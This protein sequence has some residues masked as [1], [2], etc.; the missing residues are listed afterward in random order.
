MSRYLQDAVNTPI[1]HAHPINGSQLDGNRNLSSPTAYYKPN[2]GVY[3]FVDP[4][5]VATPRQL[6]FYQRDSFGSL[7]TTVALHSFYQD[8][9]PVTWAW[10]DGTPNTVGNRI[11]RHT[12]AAA[13]TYTVTASATSEASG[14]ITASVSVTVDT[15]SMA[16]RNTSVP[17]VT[18][19]PKV[20]T[21][22]VGSN[23][24]WTGAT[25]GLYQYQWS[26]STG[27]AIVGATAS[28]YTPVAGDVGEQLVFTVTGYNSRGH[29]SASA[30]ATAVVAA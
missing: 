30:V 22:L 27:A 4:A 21:Q 29:A 26:W 17:T 8:L 10:G 12:F 25:T 23:G 11:S 18:G 2:D 16:P 14:A 24:T 20:G 9:G 5:G 7:G 15:A 1:G 28:N 3:A 6:V 19:T 13:G